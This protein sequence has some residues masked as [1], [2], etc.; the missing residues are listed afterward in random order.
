[1]FFVQATERLPQARQSRSTS[2]RPLSFE[3]ILEPGAIA[4]IQHWLYVEGSNMLAMAK[5]GAK[6][7]RIRNAIAV[8]GFGEAVEPHEVLVIGQDQFLEKARGIIWDC[9][10]FEHGLAAVP[11]DF[12]TAQTRS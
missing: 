12:S 8:C 1:M 5:H 7:E 9:R 10:G 6:V 3:D 4:A 2:F 11:M